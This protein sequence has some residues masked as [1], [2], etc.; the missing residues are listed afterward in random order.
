MQTVQAA[1]QEGGVA[2]QVRT[3]RKF[4]KI[5][6]RGRGAKYWVPQHAL[7]VLDVLQASGA[8]PLVAL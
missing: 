7:H 3:L 8:T 1:L 2:S 4:V 6:A 5:V